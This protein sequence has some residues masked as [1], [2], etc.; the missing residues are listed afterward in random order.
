MLALLRTHTL[1]TCTEVHVAELEVSESIEEISPIV[2]EG[3][4]IK[5]PIQVLE[6]VESGEQVRMASIFY[7]NMSGLL[8]ETLNNLSMSNG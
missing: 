8:P 7:R 6:G 5:V 3:T 2:R 1:N 4:Q